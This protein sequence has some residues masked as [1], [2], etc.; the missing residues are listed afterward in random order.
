LLCV[1]QKVLLTKNASQARE[2][3]RQNLAFY[4]PLTNYRSNWLRIG[5]TEDDLINGGSNRFLDAMVAWGNED[6]IRTRIKAH[7]DA[8][9]DHVCI[10]P[11]RADGVPLPDYNAIKALAD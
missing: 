8:G 3:A 7:I 4:M 5:F 11:L 2:I 1:E 10:Q 9:A 6:S